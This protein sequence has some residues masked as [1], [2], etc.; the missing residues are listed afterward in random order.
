MKAYIGSLTT[1]KQF[2]KLTLNTPSP[3]F[4]SIVNC[5][6]F[7]NRLLWLASL[8][9][10]DHSDTNFNSESLR[11]LI[12]VRTKVAAEERKPLISFLALA[13]IDYIYVGLSEEDS[14]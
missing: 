8:W 11:E 4:W 5:P 6:G 12:A 7:D 10:I 1:V 13:D 14:V 3:G 9:L 2:P